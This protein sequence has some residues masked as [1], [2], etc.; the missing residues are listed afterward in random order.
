MVL[1]HPDQ[2]VMKPF[3]QHYWDIV[4]QDVFMVVLQFFNIKECNIAQLQLPI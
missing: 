3:F 1:G 4:G 2:M